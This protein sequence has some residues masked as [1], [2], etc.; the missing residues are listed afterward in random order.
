VFFWVNSFCSK[1]QAKKTRLWAGKGNRNNKPKEK[2]C[3]L[4]ITEK[5]Q[6]SIRMKTKP[7]NDT[8]LTNDTLKTEVSSC[9]ALILKRKTR[10]S[11]TCDTMTPTFYIGY[12][13]RGSNVSIC[14]YIYPLFVYMFIYRCHRC[15]RW[16]IG[17]REAGFKA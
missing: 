3:S 17:R 1:Q 2:V 6:M 10:L 11:D 7:K 9:N 8:F 14:I 13:N 15:H 16:Y 12:R 5:R 4:I